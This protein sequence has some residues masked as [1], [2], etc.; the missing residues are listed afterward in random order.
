MALTDVYDA[1]ANKRVYKPALPYEEIEDYIKQQSGKAFDP[2][3]VNVFFLV[4]D[5]LKEINENNKD[6][7]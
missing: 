4:K 3:V 1:L 2:K 7:E 5:K 6:K